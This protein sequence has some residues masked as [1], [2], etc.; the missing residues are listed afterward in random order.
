MA[1]VR[2]RI[3]ELGG[4]NL[5]TEWKPPWRAELRA[6][7]RLRVRVRVCVQVGAEFVC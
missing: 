3:L 1:R 7:M 6:R 2:V 5:P 4:S